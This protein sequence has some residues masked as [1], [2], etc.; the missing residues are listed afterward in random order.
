MAFLRTAS[1][2]LPFA[3]AREGCAACPG[4]RPTL[5]NLFWIFVIASVL[6][7][8]VETVVA[9][10]MDGYVK[11]RAGLMWGPFSPLYGL[12]AVLM[13]LALNGLRDH[14]PLLLFVASALVGGALEFVAGW[15]WKSAFGIVAW[16]YIG[17]PLNFGGFTCVEMMAV[18]GLAGLAWAR[19]GIPLVMRIVGLI[20]ERLRKPLTAAL[21][22]F[23]AV[24]V[25][26]T[27]LGFNFW[28]ERLEGI[29]PDTPL[30]AFFA[31]HY[32]NDWMAQR[33]Q[34]M[35]LWTDIANR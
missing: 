21:A 23:L 13:T 9:A 30:S 22:V 16:S 1:Q 17:R 35:S 3:Q 12:G 25:A 27:L 2:R 19:V 15:F 7:L 26:A 14:S 34:T 5:Y 11:D 32:G 8:V 4:F 10:F 6:G 18:W 29:S 24:D 33:F 28:F 20:P 31:E